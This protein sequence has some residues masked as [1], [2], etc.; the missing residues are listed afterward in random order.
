[1]ASYKAVPEWWFLIILAVSIA[2]SLLMSVVLRQDVQL[3]W[4]GFIFAS[5]LA[6]ALT[7]PIGVIQATT[8]QVI[9]RTASLKH[10]SLKPAATW[11]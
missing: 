8:N 6:W 1:M 9:D 2:L 11:I 10:F 3:P 4:W 5:G 7:L